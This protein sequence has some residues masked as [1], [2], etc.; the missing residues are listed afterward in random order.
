MSSQ[1]TPLAI[2]MNKL[3]IV[4][5]SEPKYFAENS[6]LAADIEVASGS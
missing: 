6:K 5:G 1:L 3:S 4:S 2:A